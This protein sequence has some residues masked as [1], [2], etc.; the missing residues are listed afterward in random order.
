ME[1]VEGQFIFYK[2]S[3][4][5]LEARTKYFFSKTTHIEYNPRMEK[6]QKKRYFQCFSLKAYYKHNMLD[7]RG[8]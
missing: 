3:C 2:I 8:V 7:L 6:C 5:H 1:H 4:V